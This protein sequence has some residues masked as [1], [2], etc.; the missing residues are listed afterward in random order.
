[1]LLFVLIYGS[2]SDD[3][4]C[5]VQ[6][7]AATALPGTH[8]SPSCASGQ[9]QTSELIFKKEGFLYYLPGNF[10]IISLRLLRVSSPPPPQVVSF[11]CQFIFLS[12]C[13]PLFL[14]LLFFRMIWQ[15]W[16]KCFVQRK[17]KEDLHRLILSMRGWLS[18]PLFQIEF[19][20]I[21]YVLGPPPPAPV[22]KRLLPL[23]L[24]TR[25]AQSLLGVAS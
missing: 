3:R 25:L 17:R 15:H 20:A 22:H 16:R 18:D 8:P 2:G 10:L 11:H 5:C 9:Q 19:V 14:L 6:A 12:K 24:S 1:M 21:N 13:Q 4:P 23:T 7:W